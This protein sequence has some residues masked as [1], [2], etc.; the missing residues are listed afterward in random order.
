MVVRSGKGGQV[1][2]TVEGDGVVGGG[3]TE[4]TGVSGDGTGSD[5][6]RCLGTNKETISANNSVG[7]E[8]GALVVSSYA[9]DVAAEYSP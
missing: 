4:S 5:I 1:S 7:S 6:V 3:V 8:G 9:P 2:E